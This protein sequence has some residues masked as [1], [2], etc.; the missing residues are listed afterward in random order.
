MTMSSAKLGNV[1]LWPATGD[2]F[3][4][5]MC[6]HISKEQARILA[7][8]LAASPRVVP[9][10]ELHTNIG[11]LKTQ[12]ARLRAILRESGANIIIVTSKPIGMYAKETGG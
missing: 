2:M 4:E 5:K 6:H 3:V 11:S 7:L 1:T 8:L 10:Q 9:H 12:I